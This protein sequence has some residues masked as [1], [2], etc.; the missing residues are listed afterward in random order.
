[1]ASEIALERWIDR[2]LAVS[3][4]RMLACIS[5]SGLSRPGPRRGQTMVPAPGSVLAAPEPDPGTGEPDYFFHWFRDA[6]IVMDAVSTLAALG[7]LPEG[8][9]GNLAAFVRFELGLHGLDGRRLLADGWPPELLPK[10]QPYL[11]PREELAALQGAAVAADVRC[12]P[13]GSPD[14]LRWSRPQYDGPAL[15]ALTVRRI[16]DLGLLTQND[17][18]EAAELLLRKDLDI[19]AAHHAVDSYDPWEEERGRHFY[20]GLVQYAALRRGAARAEA[21]GDAHWPSH[22]DATAEILREAL[23]AHWS[24]EDGFY[25]SRLPGP[26]ISE[27]KTLDSAVL[28]AVLHADL[29]DGPFSVADPKVQATVARLEAF[30]AEELPVNRGRAPSDGL[31]L[32]RYPGDSYLGGGAFLPCCFA[33]AE[34]RY[35]RAERARGDAILA[36]LARL[37]PESGQ[38]PEQLDRENGTLR[39]ARDLAWSHA[40]FVT[41]V[42]ARRACG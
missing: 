31:V 37:L 32:G 25:R 30:F 34:Y 5:A 10:L 39:S 17:D 38:L 9:D 12:N 40:A 27:S 19:C 18:R 41:A 13:D 28:L 2:Q 11:R 36:F 3:V 33:L 7:R 14:L 4:R 24:E 26:G 15:R 20:T 42:E 21:A 23:A 29:P 8:A 16:L 35:R 6:A 22:L 1:M